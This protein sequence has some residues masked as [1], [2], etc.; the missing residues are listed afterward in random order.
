MADQSEELKNSKAEAKQLREELKE[1]LFSSR[2]IAQEAG[3]LAKGLG[4]GTIEAAAFKKAFK[5]TADI[6]K[7]LSS[8][9]DKIIAG[10]G[11]SKNIQKQILKNEQSKRDIQRESQQI[12]SK[13]ASQTANLT[14]EEKN[15]IIS[16]KTRTEIQDLQ[17]RFGRD[18]TKE[19]R[20]AL[21]LTQEQ[22]GNNTDNSKVLA[23][24]LKK[25]KDI[26]KTTG[27]TGKIIE[28]ISKIPLV[29]QF[30][31][32]AAAL[33]KMQAA[34]AGGAGK[35]E[36]MFIGLKSVGKDIAA[37]LTDPLFIMTQLVKAGL[38]FDNSLTKIEKS[39]GISRDSS[40]F[41]RLNFTALAGAS[42]NLAISSADIQKSF[43]DL[44]EQ[45]GTASTVLRDDILVES[46]ELMKLTGQ[47]AESVAN[48]AKFANISGKNMAVVTKE[49]RAAVV[50]AEQENGVRLDIN[51]VLEE[52]G[53]ITGQIAAQLGGNPEKIA[54]AVAVAKQFG[55]TL[56]GVAAAGKSLL[57]FEESIN[58]ELEA[59]L[60][61]G[62]N[63]NLE[64]A[65]LA[66][67]TGDY[68]TL[69]KEINAN[70]GDF[71]DFTKMNVLQQEAL[72][73]SVGMTADALA[74]QLL[75]KANLEQLA[76]EA[77]A[78][79][80]ED[81][82]KQL[83][84]RSAQESFNDAVAKLKGLFTD[85]VGGPV[86]A[87]L[88]V[89]TLALV[90]ISLAANGLSGIMTLFTDG[91]KELT[92]MESLL[93]SVAAAF[94]VIKG[95]MLT[96]KA[97]QMAT[98][99]VK[100]IGLG[101]DIATGKVGAKNILS[102]NAGLGKNVALA[103]AK[104]FSSFSAIPF[105]LGIPLAIASVIGMAA[106]VKKMSKADDGIFEGGGYGKR[107][108]LD[109]G[110]VTLFNNKDT[111]VAGTNLNKGDD[112][113]SKPAG[114]VSM[115]PAFDYEEM[116]RVFGNMSINATTKFDDFGSRSNLARTGIKNN[117]LKNQSSFA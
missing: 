49:A 112:V 45:F 17:L 60:L 92:F 110:S 70:V 57:N 51:K 43:A 11:K 79:G 16:A 50:A 94:L 115:A 46:A 61:T 1:I 31:D 113:I 15:A 90:P 99:I 76:Q 81:L 84:A 80:D 106:L 38:D 22:L 117:N 72:A 32:S 107:A 47:S 54:K 102:L 56:E 64:R 88:D 42:N 85:I 83:E 86:S 14:K 93:G 20:S 59:E 18:L 34:A 77:R 40:A 67:L 12:L 65:R 89:L 19:Q 100:G 5:D 33:E 37:G 62:K 71:G 69:T 105:G 3:L 55:M 96:I 78:G 27:L 9:S 36:T 111:I 74:D 7:E 75:S 26:E 114:S 10:Q 98:N 101:F 25:Q 104:I 87:L 28:G 44:N 68:E 13:I 63:L 109:E 41:V 6:A 2:D 29:G 52:T 108:L 103:A 35:V 4:L 24:Q 8:N 91:N 82:A 53:K 48:F 116:G 97:I 39:L 58:A 95:T 23:D 30:V 66:A 21:D 73:K